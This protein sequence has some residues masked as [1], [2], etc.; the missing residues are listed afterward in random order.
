MKKKFTINSIIHAIAYFIYAILILVGEIMRKEIY[1]IDGFL[2]ALGAIGI[3]HSGCILAL[4]LYIYKKENKLD[5]IPTIVS[6]SFIAFFIFLFLCPI[7][8]DFTYN[9]V[10]GFRNYAVYVYIL[11]TLLFV[12]QLLQAS[13]R[14]QNSPKNAMQL[15]KKGELYSTFILAVLALASIVFAML[16]IL[17]PNAMDL[18]FIPLAVLFLG[19]FI[20]YIVRLIFIYRINK[21]LKNLN[22]SQKNKIVL[23]KEE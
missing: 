19:F 20:Y 23:P 16:M 6:G 10:E 13:K 18:Y 15:W 12:Y 14:L 9:K 1:S 3:I 22:N 11:V 2:F 5:F 8:W 4:L 21:K 17:K 7:L